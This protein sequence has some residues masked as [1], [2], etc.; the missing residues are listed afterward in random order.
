MEAQRTHQSG[1][2]L[3]PKTEQLNADLWKFIKSLESVKFLD[4][5]DNPPKRIRL[6]TDTTCTYIEPG[7]KVGQQMCVTLKILAKVEYFTIHVYFLPTTYSVPSPYGSDTKDRNKMSFFFDKKGN[8]AKITVEFEDSQIRDKDIYRQF[9]PIMLT[10]FPVDFTAVGVIETPNAKQRLV[11]L[12]QSFKKGEI[13]EDKFKEHLAED[14][15]IKPFLENGFNRIAIVY[16]E[17]TAFDSMPE[18]QV[19]ISDKETIPIIAAEKVSGDPEPQ[20]TFRVY[21]G[22][23][24]NLRDNEES[25]YFD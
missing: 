8:T 19:S 18:A 1:E 4:N 10:E 17:H 22:R 6:E 23:K 5:S 20:I 21:D 2:M 9:L 25:W 16:I 14:G 3:N 12:Y 11:D 15:R 24:G 7:V 13:S